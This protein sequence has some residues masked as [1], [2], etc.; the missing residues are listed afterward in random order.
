MATTRGLEDT[1]YLGSTRLERPD[2]EQLASTRHAETTAIAR[3]APKTGADP[4]IFIRPKYRCTDRDFRVPA[5]VPRCLS[6]HQRSNIPQGDH[7]GNGESGWAE[8]VG[9]PILAPPGTPFTRR[10]G[11]RIQVIAMAECSGFGAELAFDDDNLRRISPDPARPMENSCDT[12]LPRCSPARRRDAPANARDSGEDGQTPAQ[13]DAPNRRRTT[14]VRR[15][16][17][18]A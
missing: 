12:A 18:P 13:W 11:W 4:L 15:R 14:T 7:G 9:K 1:P 3:Q 16:N 2:E 8:K 6:R 10:A 17:L 5:A